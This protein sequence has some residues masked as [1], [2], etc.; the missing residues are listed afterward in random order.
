MTVVG[1]KPSRFVHEA[2]SSAGGFE[3]DDA[4][5]DEMPNIST[6]GEVCVHLLSSIPF[7]A[8]T[9][10]DATER[11]QRIKTRDWK[12]RPFAMID[13]CCMTINIFI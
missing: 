1:L 10:N 8:A 2:C 4:F 5:S 9:A 13:W 11:N 7:S 3:L 12:N 6:H